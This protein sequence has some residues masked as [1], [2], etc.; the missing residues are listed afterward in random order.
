MSLPILAF[1]WTEIS[2][3]WRSIAAS[4]SLTAVSG[5]HAVLAF[6]VVTQAVCVSSVNN[7]SSVRACAR[8]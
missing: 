7:L 2:D 6:N 8:A 1:M 3:G 5:L 4:S